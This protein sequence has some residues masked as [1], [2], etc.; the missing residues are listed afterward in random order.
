MSPAQHRIVIVDDH[1][2]FR[3]GI[4]ALLDSEPDIEVVGEAEDGL[5]AL[6]AAI[7]L[8]P[9]L[10]LSD[11]SMPKTSG[12]EG[13]RQIRRRF[14]AIGIIVLTVHKAEEY[15]RAA[16]AAG[17]NGYVLKDDSEQEL[18]TAI[19]QV[20]NKNFYLSPNICNSV[21]SGFLGE[22]NKYASLP[23][24]DSLTPR[25]Q[26]VLKLIAEGYRNKAIADYLS[27]SPKTVEKHRGNL[28]RKLDLHDVSSLT[29]Y[30]INNGII[31]NS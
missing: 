14:P 22:R 27:I 5:S 31:D 1:A 17:A 21:V 10:I 26:Q 6:Q 28:M 8:K 12:T 15:I 30:A 11:L 29:I 7:N 19:H 20:S 3:A 24:W 16:L 25:E 2:I 13:I 4:K 9:D 18:L 23:T